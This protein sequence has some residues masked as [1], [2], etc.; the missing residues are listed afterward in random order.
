M[1]P[2]LGLLVLRALVDVAAVNRLRA[3][4]HDLAGAADWSAIAARPSYAELQRRRADPD[5]GPIA[6]EFRQR[7][8]GPYLGGPVDWATGR[9]ARR[10]T[11]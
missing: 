10:E 7:H 4:S 6:R 8:G 11:A 3:M 1:S 5:P 2:V 9:P